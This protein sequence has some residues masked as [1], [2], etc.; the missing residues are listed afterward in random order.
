MDAVSMKSLFKNGLCVKAGALT[1]LM[2][3]TAVA[4][5]QA[6]STLLTVSNGDEKIV[7]DLEIAACPGERVRGLQGRTSLDDNAG[8]LFLIEPVDRVSMWMKDT[9]IPLDILFV[10]AE[11]R[12][13][14]LVESTTPMSLRSINSPQVVAAVVETK[15]GFISRS[16]IR[17]GQSVRY[18]IS[19][20]VLDRN[21]SVKDRV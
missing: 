21:C 2:S 1:L 20:A 13:V 5:N 14:G 9:Y 10:D 16:G 8:M 7:L 12:I 6:F 11:D 3:M 17:L 18:D 19:D 4:E 15:A